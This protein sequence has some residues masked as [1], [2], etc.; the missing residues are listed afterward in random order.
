[1]TVTNWNTTTVNGEPFLVIDAA[2][3]CIPLNWDPS[4][5]FFIAVAAPNGIDGGAVGSFGPLVKGDPGDPPTLDTA[6][7]LTALEPTDPTADSASFTNLGSNVYQLNLSLHKGQPGATGVLTLLGATDLVG[8]PV[9][10]QIVVVNPTANGFVYATPKVGDRFIPAT[11]LSTPSGNPGYTLCSVLVAA[12]D[13][14]WRPQISGYSI[15]T[16][17]SSDVAVDLIARL[18]TETS[19][20][21]IARAAGIAGIGPTNQV[22]VSAPPA[23]SPDN[24]DRVTAGNA[25]TIYL[26][27]ERQSGTGTFTTSAS[28]TRFAVRCDPVP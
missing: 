22:F 13:F 5:N 25:A 17:T 2:Q 10:G 7:N 1:M 27:A 24:W 26:R 3:F 21:D 9:S 18:N 23:G 19:G 20:N 12:Q 4:S 15:V 16:G 6:I 14:D 8:S 11:I 28:T